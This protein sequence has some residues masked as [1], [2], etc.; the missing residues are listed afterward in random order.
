MPGAQSIVGIQ[1]GMDTNQIVD[2][3]ITFERQNAVLL[4]LQQ[5]EKTNIVSAYKALQAKFLALSTEIA[6]LKRA[7]TFDAAQIQISDDTYLS[8][9][10]T[11]RVGV[12]SYD[13]QVLSL[14][15]NHQLA[16]QGFS[17]KSL[18]DFGA[19]TISIAVGDGSAQMITINAG[20]NSLVG[21]KTAINNA[22]VG[23]TASI[24]NDG[25]TSNAHRLILTGNQTGEANQITVTSS[26]SGGLNL[27]FDNSSFDAAETVRFASGTTSSASLGASAA[28]TGSVNKTYTFTV[29]GSGEQTVG[30]DTITLNWTDGANSGSIEIA[31]AD[32]EV[33]LTGGGADGLTIQLAAGKMTAGDKFQVSTFAP[34]LQ[35]ASDARV[36]LGSSGGAGSPIEITST[37]NTF[38]DVISGLTLNVLK[39]TAAGDSITVNTDVDTG[40]IK[41]GI[42]DFIQRYNDVMEFIDKQN[43]YNQDTGESGVLFGDFTLWSMQNSLRSALAAR[44]VGIDGEFTHLY[45]VGIRTMA[46]GRLALANP[47]KLE[48]ALRNNLD[49]VIKLFSDSGQS[50][51]SFIEFMSAGVDTDMTG[52]FDVDISQAA[53]QGGYRGAGLLNPD[54][55][56]LILESTTNRLKL[57]IDG[58]NSDELVLAAKTYTSAD[59]LVAEIQAKIDAD[60]RIGKF[61][62]TVEWVDLGAGGYLQFH[63]ST[64]GSNSKVEIVTGVANNAYQALG[65]AGGAVMTG[66]DVAGAINGEEARG[67]GQYLTGAEDNETTAG[68]KLKVTLTPGQLVSG[69]DGSITLSQGVASKLDKML[70]SLTKSGD[71]VFDRRIKAYDN[72]VQHLQERITE[73]DDRLTLRREALYKQFYEMELTLSGLSAQSDYLNAQ[74]T[75]M[76]N[77]WGFRGYGN[78]NR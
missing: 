62:V 11:G 60:A 7:A 43:T 64:Y 45:A 37:T 71:G 18:A 15:R 25:S 56:D 13:V 44:I 66:Q 54:S 12:G 8:V 38:R 3:I 68:L 73:I 50:T 42:A 55:T 40:G 19:G 35:E 51:N 20:N 75:N 1:S 78:N 53:T 63:S 49:D 26:L 6:R 46:T 14:A 23:V 2:A 52:T 36:S 74:L 69:A 10:A 24:I 34:V 41:S 4:E 29:A 32:T 48:A 39:E 47:S 61:G 70:D 77:L 22:D 21:I 31:A 67:T 28:Y 72:Q 58:I 5:A 76:N 59:E 30:S 33:A 16:S 17:D 65:L 27:D 57:K 9:S